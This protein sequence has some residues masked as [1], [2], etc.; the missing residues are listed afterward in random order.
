M[1]RRADKAHIREPIGHALHFV[2]VV[3]LNH[4]SAAQRFAE[5]AKERAL[6][7]EHGLRIVGLMLGLYCFFTYCIGFR[8]DR[9]ARLAHPR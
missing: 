6:A 8:H 5:F 9:A 7:R 4:I 3:G 1:E 2:N